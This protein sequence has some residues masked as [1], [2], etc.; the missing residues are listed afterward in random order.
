MEKIESLHLS[1]A[2]GAVD[3][4]IGTIQVPVDRKYVFSMIAFNCATLEDIHVY[5]H[6]ELVITYTRDGDD[7]TDH[8]PL[9]W[10]MP[11]GKELRIYGTNGAGAAALMGVTFNYDDLPA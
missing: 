1:V 7:S 6:D 5:L 11:G 3:T 8:W 10:E 2:A 4:L 9:N